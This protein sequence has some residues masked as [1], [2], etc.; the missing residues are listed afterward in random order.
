M[1]QEIGY[2]TDYKPTTEIIM[3]LRKLQGRAVRNTKKSQI[4]QAKKVAGHVF[5]LIEGVKVICKHNW[6]ENEIKG[7]KFM[8]PEQ[9]EKRL[10]SWCQKNKAHNYSVNEDT[11]NVFRACQEAKDLG[12][13]VLIV[14]MVYNPE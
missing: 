6:V 4:E 9:I 13:D 14:E 10:F 1:L 7:W 5:Q 2:I 8:T 11:Y 12:R 3:D